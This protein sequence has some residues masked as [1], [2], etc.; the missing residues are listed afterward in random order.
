VVEDDA[1]LLALSNRIRS[2]PGV[3]STETFIY[4]SLMKQTYAWGAH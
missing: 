4:L 3:R 1:A 2:V